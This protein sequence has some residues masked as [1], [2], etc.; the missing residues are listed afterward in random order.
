[1]KLLRPEEFTDEGVRQCFVFSSQR[2]E[3][4]EKRSRNVPRILKRCSHCQSETWVR[5]PYVRQSLQQGTASKT[6]NR[7]SSSSNGCNQKLGINH[8]R[9]NG[10]KI[11]K[12]GYVLVRNSCRGAKKKYVQEHRVV[13]ESHLGRK[14]LPVETIHHKNG[15]RH[16]NRIEN[17]ELRFGSHGSG[18]AY[19]DLSPTEIKS[20]IAFLEGLLKGR[21]W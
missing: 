6:C 19:S 16:D 1:M 7:C 9:W 5:V 20:L 4:D 8:H 12:N 2:M 18:V 15:I 13:M 14:L 3:W 17:L 11:I 10:G 21:E